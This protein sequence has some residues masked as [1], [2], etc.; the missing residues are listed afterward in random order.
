MCS[1]GG[2]RLRMAAGLISSLEG[3][4][5]GEEEDADKKG[6]MDEAVASH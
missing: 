4:M 6:A 5:G 1:G 2:A 3:G